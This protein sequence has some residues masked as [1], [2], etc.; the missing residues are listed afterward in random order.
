VSS[1]ICNASPLI[2]LAKSQLLE[3]LPKLFSEIL[4]PQAVIEEI[5]AGPPD[6]AACK[7][8][9]KC[10]W[11]KV[12]VL[13]PP[14]SPLSAWQLGKGEAEVIEYARLHPQTP[15]ILDDRAARR[16]AR[17]LGISLYGTLS[18]VA[19]YTTQGYIKSFRE[20]VDQLRI[21]GL[22]LSDEIIEQVA[23]RLGK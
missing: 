15:A 22:Y 20:A 16:A 6:D 1:V 10:H 19:M 14:L 21:A 2:V 11:L 3:P 7:V 8:L 13:N 12:V 18:I 5:N 17:S 23:T 4:V 9:P